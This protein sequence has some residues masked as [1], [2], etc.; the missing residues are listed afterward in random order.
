MEIKTTCKI[1]KLLAIASIV[2][3]GY[4]SSI[5]INIIIIIIIIIAL[6]N[7]ILC[8]DLQEFAWR[9]GASIAWIVICLPLTM[10]MF[11]VAQLLDA[12]H[13]IAWITGKKNS[14]QV[15]PVRNCFLTFKNRAKNFVVF[16]SLT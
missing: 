5:N 4:F 10:F 3:Y 7:T 6:K 2:A 13:P 15:S 9:T 16:K 1:V 11:H 8:L 14:K 12:F